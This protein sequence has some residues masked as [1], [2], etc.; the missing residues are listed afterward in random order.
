LLPSYPFT[1]LRIG[2]WDPEKSNS[3]IWMLQFNK[4]VNND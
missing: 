1:I 4:T 3:R 2:Q